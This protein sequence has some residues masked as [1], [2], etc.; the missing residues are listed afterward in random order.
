MIV[1]Q[2]KAELT[3]EDEGA[4]VEILDQNDEPAMFGGT[5]VEKDGETVIEG[6]QPVTV[7]VIGM[8]SKGYAKA[9]AWQNQQIQ[10]RRGRNATEKQQREEF[11]GFLARCM[12]GW[13][14]FF[15]EDGSELPFTTENAT[16]VL[17][18]LPFVRRQV[19]SAVGNGRLFHSKAA[20]P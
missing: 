12:R 20:T 10:A 6:A 14:G 11:A 7:R 8:N 9:E 4:I 19:A 18:A 13:A 3:A 15:N 16:E 17:L 1:A 5:T 2:V